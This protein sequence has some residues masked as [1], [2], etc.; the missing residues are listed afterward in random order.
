M[1][2][3]LLTESIMECQRYPAIYETINFSTVAKE[4]IEVMNDSPFSQSKSLL[5]AE[6]EEKK[7]L[8]KK[9]EELT[10]RRLLLEEVLACKKKILLELF[11]KFD[12]FVEVSRAFLL[13]K[14]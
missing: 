6:L 10:N 11:D 14:Q 3:S 8:R 1:E 2:N 5:N 9:Q 13:D 12:K 7:R 4:S